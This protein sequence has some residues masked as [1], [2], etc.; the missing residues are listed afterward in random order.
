MKQK[1][2]NKD[3]KSKHKQNSLKVKYSVC[4]LAKKCNCEKFMFMIRP[5]YVSYINNF[6]ISFE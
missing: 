6:A 2:N 4:T 3:N 5:Y 1:L